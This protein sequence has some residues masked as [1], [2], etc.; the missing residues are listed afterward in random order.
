VN[1]DKRTMQVAGALFV[2]VPMLWGIFSQVISLYERWDTMND[3]VN[4][5]ERWRCAM[6]GKPPET[7]D[8]KRSVSNCRAD[9]ETR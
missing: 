4:R 2:I 1:V 7:I 3:R 5:L 9:W 6:G 8:W